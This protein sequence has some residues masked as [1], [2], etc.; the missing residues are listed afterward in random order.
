MSQEPS[1]K[2][3]KRS[4]DSD[5]VDE[6]LQFMR[7]VKDATKNKDDYTVYGDVAS[8]MRRANRSDR[9]VSLAKHYIDDVLFRLEMGELDEFYRSTSLAPTYSST[10][11]PCLSVHTSQKQFATQGYSDS[12]QSTQST[13]YIVPSAPPLGSNEESRN[14][15]NEEGNISE[16]LLL[17]D[18]TKN[19]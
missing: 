10:P 18:T 17:S 7:S 5:E 9:A 19:N 8:R 1:K 12:E 2:K 3:T 16:F 6:A 11:S 4:K 14:F 13:L 15:H